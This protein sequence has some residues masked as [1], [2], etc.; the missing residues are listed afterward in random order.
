MGR[1]VGAGDYVQQVVHPVAQINIQ[2]PRRAVQYLRPGR[3][4][5]VGV[6]GG[7]LLAPIGFGLA[8]AQPP[9]ATVGQPMAQELAHQIG[10]NV[11]T[12]SVEKAR[13]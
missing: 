7:V 6:A 8:D 10:G 11:Q 13:V 3:F 1:A 9:Q 5:L 4:A 12:V 2:H